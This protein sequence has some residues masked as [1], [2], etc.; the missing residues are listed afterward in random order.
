MNVDYMGYSL[1]DVAPEGHPNA[2]LTIAQ[3]M[4]KYGLDPE[5]NTSYNRLMSIERA[6]AVKAGIAPASPITA[7][8]AAAAQLLPSVQ[9]YL[10]K[11]RTTTILLVGGAALVLYLATRKRK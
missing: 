6:E 10:A 8:A 5:D 7:E 1:T 2:G 9:D 3:R 4:E 11:K